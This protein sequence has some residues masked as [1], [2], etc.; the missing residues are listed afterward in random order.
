MS[1]Q[2]TP[3]NNSSL[4]QGM[5]PSAAAAFQR[6]EEA[7]IVAN[8]AKEKA[9]SGDIEGALEVAATI[10]GGLFEDKKSFQHISLCLAD[11]EDYAGALKVAHEHLGEDFLASALAGIAKIMAGK[12]KIEEA[13]EIAYGI[14][15]DKEQWKGAALL[16]ISRRLV[17]RGELG[18]AEKVAL[19]VP[20]W[21]DR[22]GEQGR[23]YFCS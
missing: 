23:K 13:L 19:R 14:P 11:R 5:C 9:D 22:K 18:K 17:R 20:E 10:E 7:K 8:L 16:E 4:A 2:L 1:Y 15:E 12:G 21:D 6:W 3:F